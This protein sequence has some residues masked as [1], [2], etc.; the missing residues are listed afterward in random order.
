MAGTTLDVLPPALALQ[1]N[2][3]LLIY[4]PQPGNLLVPYVGLRCTTGQVA[5][6]ITGIG[7]INPSMR[8]LIA[9]LAN[10]GVL[11]S[12]FD[13]LP[14]DITNSYN[15][16]YNHAY[17]MTIG[18]SFVTGFLQPTLGYSGAQMIALFDLALSFPI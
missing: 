15:I 18:D 16:A 8:Q 2:E 7:T 17:V 6:L 14:A 11:V 10:Q 9:A 12:V 1:G 5:E 3:L 4:Q 13:A